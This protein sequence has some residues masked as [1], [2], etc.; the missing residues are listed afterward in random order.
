MWDHHLMIFFSTVVG[1]AVANRHSH[2][3]LKFWFQCTIVKQA[4]SRASFLFL[5]LFYCHIIFSP[6]FSSHSWSKTDSWCN[7]T[8]MVHLTFRSSH[9][10]NFLFLFMLDQ[11]CCLTYFF[12]RAYKRLMFK[13]CIWNY[14]FD[15]FLNSICKTITIS[16]DVGFPKDPF[17]QYYFFLLMQLFGAA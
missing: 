9:S 8:K 11:S 7:I 16:I 5:H 3:M 4:M 1:S 17:H 2:V 6:I 12:L 13:S 10:F 14:A 15:I